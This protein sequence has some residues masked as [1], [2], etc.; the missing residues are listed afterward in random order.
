MNPTMNRLICNVQRTAENVFGERLPLGQ[1][2]INPRT[3]LQE[4]IF[5]VIC[6]YVNQTVRVA[7]KKMRTENFLLILKR[8]INIITDVHNTKCV[9]IILRQC[10]RKNINQPSITDLKLPLMRTNS[11]KSHIT[12]V[13]PEP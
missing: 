7:P 1:V 4:K 9:G 10:Q 13:E 6:Y 3:T 12:S 5:K 2:L 11:T 8:N